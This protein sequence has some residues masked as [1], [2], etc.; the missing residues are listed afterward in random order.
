ML[1]VVC[2]AKSNVNFGSSRGFK[3]N[4]IVPNSSLTMILHFYHSQQTYEQTIFA[5]KIKA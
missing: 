2:M 4:V 5:L 1:P 3:I